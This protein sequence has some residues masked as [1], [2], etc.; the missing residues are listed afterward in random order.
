MRVYSYI[1]TTKC[2][3]TL[4]FA[5]KSDVIYSY[6]PSLFSLITIRN[7]L[8]SNFATS[9]DAENVIL[10]ACLVGSNCHSWIHITCVCL[11]E[12]ELVPTACG[13]DSN[14]SISYA[15]SMPL[16]LFPTAVFTPYQRQLVVA[17]FPAICMALQTFHC[18]QQSGFINSL[19]NTTDDRQ[20]GSKVS[21]P[22]TN[23]KRNADTRP[24]PH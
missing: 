1:T 8:L 3:N 24:S 2:V 9:Q 11:C 14:E 22:H 13:S 6:L 4:P 17:L 10:T 16:P 20:A 5:S 21:L 7:V 12:P 23:T 15:H 19:Q 18:L